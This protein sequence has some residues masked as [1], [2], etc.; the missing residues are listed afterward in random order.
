LLY[1]VI[2]P[3]A[4]YMLSRISIKRNI[5]HT[6]SPS[7]LQYIDFGPHPGMDRLPREA[8]LARCVVITN[9]E[10]AANFEEDVPLPSEF[11]FAQ[12]DV[13]KIYSLIKECCTK[14]DEYAKKMDKYKLWI[15]AQ[16]VQMKSCVDGLVD[17]VVTKRI[18]SRKRG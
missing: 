4:K 11:K 17:E 12:F 8:T 14:H 16:R 7:S 3:Y 5:H 6:N 13:D 15:L 10:G 1:Y 9:R 18:D 2:F